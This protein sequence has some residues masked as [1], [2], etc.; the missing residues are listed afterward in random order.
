MEMLQYLEQFGDLFLYSPS[1]Y[2]HAHLADILTWFAPLFTWKVWFEEQAYQYQKWPGITVYSTYLLH[3][4][5]HY[6]DQVTPLVSINTVDN[7]SC[8]PHSM[9][10]HY[11]NFEVDDDIPEPWSIPPTYDVKNPEYREVLY[12]RQCL[13]KKLY[14]QNAI[15]PLSEEDLIL[16]KIAK[17]DA[18]HVWNLSQALENFVQEQIQQQQDWDAI[19]ENMLKTFSMTGPTSGPGP[20]SSR[21]RKLSARRR[22]PQEKQGKR[23]RQKDED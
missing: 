1:V 17:L 21:S 9:A 3:R 23:P 14:Q 13:T 11:G 10:I 16:E 15:L 18:T 4:A 8:L 7:F 12:S 19:A 5:W 20:S 6:D 2:P 22:T